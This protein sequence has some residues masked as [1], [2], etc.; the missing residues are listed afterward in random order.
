MTG[1]VN[2]DWRPPASGVIRGC[3]Q[4]S[5][6]HGPGWTRDLAFAALD[7][8]AAM[9]GPLHLDCA[10]IYTGVE[11][12]LG[13]W[14]ASRKEAAGEVVVHTKCVPDLAVLPRIK[15]GHVRRIVLRSRDRLRRDVLDLVQLHWWDFGVPGWVRA[16]GWLAELR[17]EGVVRHLGVT[18]FDAG[19]LRT[20]LDEGIPIVTNQVQFSLLDRRPLGGLTD[21][22]AER[23]VSLLCYGTLAGGLL[24]DG[25]FAGADSRSLTKYR[26]I[27]DEV[28][29]PAALQRARAA[30]ARIAAREGASVADVAAAFALTRP[31]VTAVIIGLSR[32][33][34]ATHPRTV[35][36]RPEDLAA[37]QAAVPT[38]VPGAVYEAER[39]RTG[40]H[41]RIMRY[42]LNRRRHH[43]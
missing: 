5:R 10:D 17:E 23:G 8:A 40:P 15:R 28:G 6:G 31:A 12:L 22:C 24:A 4:L 18:N 27:L 37:L 3:W 9:P 13:D 33:H 25:S 21:L 26:F 35:R 20:L 38:T 19:A 1:T 29:G 2:H 32:R 41:G 30:L 43:A 11:E 36:L 42:D 14:T 39:D 34:L 16:A 7:S